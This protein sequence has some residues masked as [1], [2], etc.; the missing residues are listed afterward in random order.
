MNHNLCSFLN[1]SL[2]NYV[3]LSIIYY[4]I[5]PNNTQTMHN[6][7]YIY[8][9]VNLTFI[10]IHKLIWKFLSYHN[11]IMLIQVYSIFFKVFTRL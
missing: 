11:Y 2:K 1:N 4:I 9:Y 7:I 6:I 10:F 3:L 5:L 8:I